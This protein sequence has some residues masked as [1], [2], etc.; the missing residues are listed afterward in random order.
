MLAQVYAAGGGVLPANP[1]RL[2]TAFVDT[3]LGR[4]ERRCEQVRWPGSATLCRALGRLAFAMQRA[5][6]RGTAVDYNWAVV[7]IDRE[8][9]DPAHVVNL[10]ASATLLETSGGRVRFVH[11]LVQEYFAALAWAE[12]IATGENLRLY[13]PNGWNEPSGW[14]ET[15]IILAGFHP[16]MTTLIE[17]LLQVNP[18]VAARCVAESGG[19]RPA[20]TT[21]NRVQQRRVALVTNPE[22]PVCERNAAG[23]ALN[24]LGD[25]R[26]GVGLTSDGLP[27]IV[28]CEVPAGEFI[29]G[30]GADQHSERIAAP[31]RISKYP[32]TNAQYAAFGSDEGYGKRCRRC[33]TEAGWEEKGDRREPE[34]WG[35][36]FDLPNHPVVRVGWYE[37]VA[38]CNWLGAKLGVEVFLPTEAQWE[39]AARWTD[40]RAYPWGEQAT[41]DHT[42][43]ADT[44]IRATC[45]VGIF[46]LGAS[47]YGAL[48]MSGNV[49][50]WCRTKWR[51]KY[52][53]Q[54][55][56]VLKG[57]D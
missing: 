15:V 9:P 8:A 20:E 52:K 2:L 34:K 7:Q 40:G 43:Y 32:I 57:G 23:D 39:K 12:L 29:M 41:P 14:E 50:E 10:A 21:V 28:W 5:G 51:D 16:D 19:A 27:D 11:Q 3:L 46:P 4:E 45:A 25:L 56:N 35:G 6:E 24:Y 30:D 36:A 47:P 54:E 17:R 44:N 31:Y 33:W 18:A 53:E 26:P 42:N 49:W 55:D 13:W 38:F 37:A 1:G 22:T 48:D